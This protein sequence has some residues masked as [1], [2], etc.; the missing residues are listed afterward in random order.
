MRAK[1]GVVQTMRSIVEAPSEG[2]P[3]LGNTDRSTQDTD[4]F[5]RAARTDRCRCR[6]PSRVAISVM[7]LSELRGLL[8]GNVSVVTRLLFY[9]MVI[10]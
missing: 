4:R 9:I 6:R 3:L 5:T 2:A 1:V 7:I 10:I 8:I